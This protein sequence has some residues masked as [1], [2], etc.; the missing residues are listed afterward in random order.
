MVERRKLKTVS[1]NIPATPEDIANL[2]T[3]D[4]SQSALVWEALLELVRVAEVL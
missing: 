3:L 2:A 4:T 1:L